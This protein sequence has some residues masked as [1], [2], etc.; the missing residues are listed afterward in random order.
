MFMY[1]MPLHQPPTKIRIESRHK[2]EEKK[3]GNINV[4]N[5]LRIFQISSIYDKITWFYDISGYYWS[6]ICGI[7]SKYWQ[8]NSIRKGLKVQWVIIL[9]KGSSGKLLIWSQK[10]LSIKIM[11]EKKQKKNRNRNEFCTEFLTFINY[12]KGGDE[13]TFYGSL[14]GWPIKVL[15]TT[16]GNSSVNNTSERVNL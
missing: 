14:I 6:Y 3:S 13:L 4:K 10:E 7:A 16:W 12:W 8:V 9:R 1:F 2:I 5:G 15:N 11:N